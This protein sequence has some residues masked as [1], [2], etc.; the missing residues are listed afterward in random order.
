[1]GK[2]V[3]QG[4]RFEAGPTGCKMSKGVR[5]VTLDVVK[6]SLLVDAKAYTTIEGARNADP[7]LVAKGVDGLPEELPSS[8]G[9]TTPSLET[10]R[11][12]GSSAEYLD[13]S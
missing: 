12:R 2:L 4:Y 13:S 8:S 7:R 9:P 1:M 10:A 6:N 3:N 11:L 5:G